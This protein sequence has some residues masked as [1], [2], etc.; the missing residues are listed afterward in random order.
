MD[1]WEGR[2]RGVEGLWVAG[3]ERKGQGGRELEEGVGTL[4]QGVLER[5][6]GEAWKGEQKLHLPGGLLGIHVLL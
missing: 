6:S 5:R 1:L 3:A 2:G 4:G